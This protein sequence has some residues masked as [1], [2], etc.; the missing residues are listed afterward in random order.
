MCWYHA[1]TILTWKHVVSSLVRNG[2]DVNTYGDIEVV[3]LLISP[4][5]NTSGARA[6]GYISEGRRG[7]NTQRIMEAQSDIHGR[8]PMHWA[9]ARGYTE[10][11]EALVEVGDDINLK[12]RYGLT[13]LHLAVGHNRRSLVT[14]LLKLKASLTST[15][16][17]ARSPLYLAVQY[18]LPEQVDE[19]LKNGPEV[20][21]NMNVENKFTPL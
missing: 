14:R 10:V 9:A 19:L 7:K 3:K 15:D 12:D 17:H 16:D 6:L 4:P 5:I 21:E 2:A 1:S 13:P 8:S 11:V 18:E 20:N